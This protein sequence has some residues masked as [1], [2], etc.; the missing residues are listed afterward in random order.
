MNIT[1]E[2][3][4]YWF[5][6]LNGFLTINNFVVHADDGLGQQTDVDVLGVRFPHRAENQIRPMPDHPEFVDNVRIQVVFVETKKAQCGLNTSWTEAT[7][8]NLE[9]VLHAGGF[10]AASEVT[11]VANNLYQTGDWTSDSLRVRLVAV[12]GAHNSGLNRKY[13]KLHQLLWREDVLPFVHERF[14]SYRDEK[15]MHGQWENDARELFRAVL[16]TGGDLS[17]FIS[18]VNIEGP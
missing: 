7:R 2:R 11:A 4:A 17:A 13:S 1:S 16:T 12:G 3:L 15:R 18:E 9:R 5:F 6:R 10:V 14:W 8:G